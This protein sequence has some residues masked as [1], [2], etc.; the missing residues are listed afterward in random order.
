M[1][2]GALP[3]AA[4]MK[5]ARNTI[6]P[7]T[8]QNRSRCWYCGGTPKYVNSTAKTNTLSIE[9]EYSMR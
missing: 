2:G 5:I 3:E 6:A 1:R 9:S 8:P 7:R 4:A